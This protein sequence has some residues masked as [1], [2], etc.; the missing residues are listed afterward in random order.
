[1]ALL[2][3]DE[4]EVDKDGSPT[5]VDLDH[6]RVL[7]AATASASSLKGSLASRMVNAASTRAG[8]AALRV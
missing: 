5:R 1:V 6:R 4:V 3:A 7:D 8:A 2:H